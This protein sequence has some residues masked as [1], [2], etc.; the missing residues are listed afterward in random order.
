MKQD[1]VQ[2]AIREQRKWIERCESNEKSSYYGDNAVAVRRADREALAALER[3]AA[4]WT[5]QDRL[6][7]VLKDL[8][9]LIDRQEDAMATVSSHMVG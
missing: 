9:K 8:D 3:R 7:R 6:E 4:R 2:Q 1:Q 5:A